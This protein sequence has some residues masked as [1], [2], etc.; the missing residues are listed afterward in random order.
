MVDIRLAL[1]SFLPSRREKGKKERAKEK[2]AQGSELGNE[3]V[4]RRDLS[5]R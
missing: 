3:R 5:S 2:E 1:K 4:A